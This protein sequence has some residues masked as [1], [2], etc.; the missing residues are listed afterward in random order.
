MKLFKW[1][2]NFKNKLIE[3]KFPQKPNSSGKYEQISDKDGNLRCPNCGHSK[4]SGGPGGGS[5]GN[6]E[7]E[8]C[9]KR[10]NNLGIFGLED[11]S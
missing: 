10:Y 6:I 7:C 5:Y 8:N 9:K 3:H 4:W 1:F 2:K 11:I